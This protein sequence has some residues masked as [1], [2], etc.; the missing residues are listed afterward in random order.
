[1]C[2]RDGR[3]SLML[4]DAVVDPE[5]DLSLTVVSVGF[6]RITYVRRFVFFT[7]SI[8]ALVLLVEP[9]VPFWV[10]Q[11]F[12][13]HLRAQE[14]RRTEYPWCEHEDRAP[15]CLPDRI[16]YATANT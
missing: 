7:S 13:F 10:V 9:E 4:L 14:L 8:V 3:F 6:F 11:P 1:M 5:P 15:F 2:E 12:I 16:A